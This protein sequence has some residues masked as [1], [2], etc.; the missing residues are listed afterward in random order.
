MRTLLPCGEKA[1]LLVKL[2]SSQIL[3]LPVALVVSR[4]HPYPDIAKLVMFSLS[5]KCLVTLTR[6]IWEV[7]GGLLVEDLL[8]DKC[9]FPDACVLAD[10]CEL[11]CDWFEE[12]LVEDDILMKYRLSLVKRR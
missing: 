6:R 12:R 9:L 3:A 8:D 11:V 4:V 2:L 1:F 10:E 7:D 5:L